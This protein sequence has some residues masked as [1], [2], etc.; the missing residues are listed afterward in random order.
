MALISGGTTRD[1]IHTQSGTGNRPSGSN[2]MVRVNTSNKC[3]EYHN[4]SS[5]Q[6]AKKPVDAGNGTINMNANNGLQC[7]GS[8]GSAN[9]STDKL[10]TV[11][12]NRTTT[13]SWYSGGPAYMDS[14]VIFAF[15]Y[16]GDTQTIGASHDITRIDKTGSGKRRVTLAKA[17][18]NNKYVMGGNNGNAGIK[19]PDTLQTTT[20]FDIHSITH[21]GSGADNSPIH[22]MGVNVL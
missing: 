2:G 17:A 21:T 15:V 13:D 14:E 16:D 18:S 6:C 5:W 3:L 4:G 11:S 20:Q 12:V 22:M 9:T 1:R 19:A 7:S 10:R 8:Q